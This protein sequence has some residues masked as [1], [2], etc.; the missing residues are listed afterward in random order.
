MYTGES[1]L[2]Y[3]H[4][5][6]KRDRA[7]ER[8]REREREREME[9]GGRERVYFHIGKFIIETIIKFVSITKFGSC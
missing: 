6:T 4:T 8:A 3:K 7:S 1:L 2:R 9:E 5:S